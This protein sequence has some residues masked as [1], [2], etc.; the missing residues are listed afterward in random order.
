[1]VRQIG[2][3]KVELMELRM[4]SL[5]GFCSGVTDKISILK[6]IYNFASKLNI[7]TTGN[8]YCKSC[9]IQALIKNRLLN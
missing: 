1:M 8:I 3:G 7:T 6:T 9:L 2:E 4:T 5:K